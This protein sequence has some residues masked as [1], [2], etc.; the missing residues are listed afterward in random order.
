MF[1]YGSVVGQLNIFYRTYIFLGTWIWKDQ[2]IRE[3]DDCEF[4]AAAV[5]NDLKSQ[6]IKYYEQNS[7]EIALINKKR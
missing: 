7:P 1:E 6:N 4:C 2:F 5:A 3:Y